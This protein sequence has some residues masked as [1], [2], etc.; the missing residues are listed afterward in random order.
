MNQPLIQERSH[1]QPYRGSYSARPWYVVVDDSM[2][3][4]ADPLSMPR[5]CQYGID[6]AKVPYP[7]DLVLVEDAVTGTLAVRRLA[8]IDCR[9]VLQPINDAF[10]A[11]DFTGV[12][13][14]IGVVIEIVRQDCHGTEYGR[15]VNKEGEWEWLQ[16]KSRS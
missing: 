4:D 13:D 10:K 12:F 5:G 1:H 6:T 3:G 16:Y 7:G 14:V 9:L 8:D 11:V 15:R 2:Q